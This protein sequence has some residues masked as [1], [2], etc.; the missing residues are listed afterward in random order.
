MNVTKYIDK[1]LAVGIVTSLTLSLILF[2]SGVDTVSSIII[3]LL[4]TILTLLI[5]MIARIEKT[6]ERYNV[7]ID[8][9]QKI[10][11]SNFRDMLNEI[12]EYTYVVE[13]SKVNKA[14]LKSLILQMEQFKDFMSELSKG[15]LHTTPNENDLILQLISEAKSY[16]RVTSLPSVSAQDWW[17]TTI[18]KKFLDA[19]G[20]AIKRDVK[21]ERI[22]IVDEY[23]AEWSRLM[24]SHFERGVSV[25]WVRLTDLPS[26]MRI[27]LAVFDNKVAYQI[28][29]SSDGKI[30]GY[31]FTVEISEVRKMERIA[32][33]IM[34]MS[35]KYSPEEIQPL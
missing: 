33:R 19:N 9:A 20:E 1:F 26:E 2:F 16:I 30:S 27:S 4:C 23:N 12:V 25:F 29:Q 13:T 14:F 21:I 35:N 18:G 3:G 6:I 34:F 5:D 11:K 32:E 10:E 31:L 7:D 22:F 17:K 28:I 15:R 24:R 8:I